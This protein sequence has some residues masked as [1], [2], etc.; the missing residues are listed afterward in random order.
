M[1][2]IS[3]RAQ[4]INAK[5]ESGK[6]YSVEEAVALLSELSTVKF[7]ETIEVSLNLGVDPRKSDQVVRGATLLPNGTGKTVRVAVF[8]QGANAEAA[9][10]AIDAVNIDCDSSTPRE[11]VYAGL[12]EPLLRLETLCDVVQLL[13]ES[14]QVDAQRLNT[15]G[16]L[17]GGA[18][19]AEQADGGRERALAGDRGGAAA[20]GGGRGGAPQC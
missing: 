9:L 15:N 3:K 18:G 8:T 13:K 1:A 6:V 16:L 7:K 5:V 4:A 20:V 11:V 2:K 12:G 19:A 10:A 17:P 14:H